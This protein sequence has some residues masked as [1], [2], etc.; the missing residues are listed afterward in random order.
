MC[1]PSVPFIIAGLGAAVQGVATVQANKANKAI[2]N[3]NISV[4]RDKAERAR[5]AGAIAAAEHRDKVRRLVGAQRANIAARG[6][7][8]DSGSYS[9]LQFE[10]LKLGASDADRIRYNAEMEALGHETNMVDLRM[11]QQLD[12]KKTQWT[13]LGS[14]LEVGASASSAW[15]E[16]K[17]KTP[18][19]P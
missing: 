16:F 5:Q 19:T 2:T 3:Y 9:D 14:A 18:K 4:E 13:V 6:F 1:H 15:G 12:N 17:P 11:R 7:D 8:P 10:T